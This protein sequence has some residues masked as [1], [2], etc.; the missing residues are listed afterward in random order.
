MRRE[1][2]A[3]ERRRDEKMRM[4]LQAAAAEREARARAIEEVCMF[5]SVFR[6]GLTCLVQSQ[7]KQMKLLQQQRARAAAR[8]QRL[9]EQRRLKVRAFTLCL[10]RISKLVC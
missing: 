5:H 9:E 2:E 7:E 6:A 8:G 1:R 4:E 10:T 3:V